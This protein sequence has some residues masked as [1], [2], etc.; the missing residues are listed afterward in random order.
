[1]KPLLPD[2]SSLLSGAV[3]SNLSCS[4]PLFFNFSGSLFY[5]TNNALILLVSLLN[6]KANHSNTSVTMVYT[7]TDVTR[8]FFIVYGVS[9]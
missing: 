8:L 7:R 4:S 2:D 9:Y 3:E 6:K 5:D 1:L